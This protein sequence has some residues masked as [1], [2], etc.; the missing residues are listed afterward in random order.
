MPKINDLEREIKKIDLELE[1]NY[2]EV[3]SKP[4]FFEIYQ[5]KKTDLQEF[6][7]KWEDIQ[8]EIEG[9]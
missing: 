8:V 3:T 9:F 2:E 5:K 7:K 1:I 6:M 4:D